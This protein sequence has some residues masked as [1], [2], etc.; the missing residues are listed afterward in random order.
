MQNRESLTIDMAQEKR[1]HAMP[2]HMICDIPGK[3]NVNKI[4]PPKRLKPGPTTRVPR[5]EVRDRCITVAL[6]DKEVEML[7]A[8]RKSVAVIGLPTRS[9]FLAYVF[10]DYCDRHRRRDLPGFVVKKK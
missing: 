1:I 7:D 4:Y 5:D 2:K 9:A 8:L 6:N 3:R 10:R